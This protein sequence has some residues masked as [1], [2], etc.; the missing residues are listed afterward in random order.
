MPETC[1]CFQ[2]LG[3]PRGAQKI[4]SRK[5][6]DEILRRAD[7]HKSWPVGLKW[8][9]KSALQTNSSGGEAEQTTCHFLYAKI[10]EEG[11]LS[12]SVSGIPRLARPLNVGQSTV[13]FRTKWDN[14]DDVSTNLSSESA[15]I[16]EAH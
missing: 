6:G 9:T 11:P 15:D 13:R 12:N 3:R 2:R 4:C 14:F 1:T 5:H 8:P 16:E 10:R 7:C